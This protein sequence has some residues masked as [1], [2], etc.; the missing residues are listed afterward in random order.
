MARNPLSNPETFTKAGFFTPGPYRIH[1]AEYVIHQPMT[2]QE[3]KATGPAKCALK[4]NASLLDADGKIVKINNDGSPESVVMDRTWNLG[5]ATDWV[6]ADIDLNPT[7]DKAG[8]HFT[9]AVKGT[10]KAVFEDSNYGFFV[11]N[12]SNSS[13]D[14]DRWEENGA[15]SLNGCIISFHEIE[16]KRDFDRD[17]DQPVTGVM[18]LAPAKPAIGK[19]RNNTIVVP[20]DVLQ[21][22]KSIMAGK[23]VEVP[24]RDAKPVAKADAAVGGK[25]NGAA[26]P[27]AAAPKQE[28]AGDVDAG[29]AAEVL[30]ATLQDYLAAEANKGKTSIVKVVAQAGIQ[31]SIAELDPVLRAATLAMFKDTE[32]LGAILTSIGWKLNGSSIQIAG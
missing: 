32:T 13:F 16:D 29:D 1:A 4:I 23:P 14:M 10:K 17:A 2:G 18:G 20:E 25:S 7:P 3:R 31:A 6:P 9:R 27:V 15:D 28:A 19:K 12:L 24:K 26:R 8:V 22:P 21:T 11:R 5:D 30:Q